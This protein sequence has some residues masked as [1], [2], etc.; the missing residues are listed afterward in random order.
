[1]LSIATPWVDSYAA[2]IPGAYVDRNVT[3]L[4]VVPE[5]SIPDMQDLVLN[6]AGKN[7]TL[8]P[9]QQLMDQSENADWGG[10]PSQESGRRLPTGVL[11]AAIFAF[12]QRHIPCQNYA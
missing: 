10:D 2:A 12:L 5:S 3:Y 8:S 4:V 1:M 9:A 6:F 7:F 11:A